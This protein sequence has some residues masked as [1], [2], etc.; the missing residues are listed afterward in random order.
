V[1]YS[2]EAKDKKL[3]LTGHSH[4]DW[5][6]IDFVQTLGQRLLDSALGGVH[7][8]PNDFTSYRSA[9]DEDR[10]RRYGDKSAFLVVEASHVED[11]ARIGPIRQSDKRDFCLAWPDG[12]MDEVKA[13][14]K[15][16][17]DQSQAFL[18]FAMPSVSGF[19]RVGSCIVADHPSGKPLYVLNAS[20]SGRA[21][22]M[23]PIPADGPELFATLFRHS[24]GSEHFQTVFRLSAGSALNAR[25][26]LRAFL[27]A[28]IAL[29]VFVGKFSDQYST[30]LDRLTEKGHSPKIHAHLERLRKDEKENVLSYKFARVSSY[31]ALDNLDEIIDEFDRANRSRNDIVHGKLF[32]EAALPIAKVRN[33]L[34]ELVRLRTAHLDAS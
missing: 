27:F 23:K 8:D 25:D 30:Q 32:D 2:N 19:E 28:F 18:T 34:G 33:W 14:H 24:V 10:V 13:R 20:V 1:L 29:E 17:L 4:A 3:S 9:T 16:F 15:T 7:F 21:S 6:H 26:D 12:F 31:L 5:N 22:V 11:G